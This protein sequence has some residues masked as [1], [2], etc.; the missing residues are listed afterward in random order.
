MALNEEGSLA[1]AAPALER[2]HQGIAECIAASRYL[3]CFPAGVDPAPFPVSRFRDPAADAT[4]EPLPDWWG[5]DER[6]LVYVSFGSVA[7]TFPDA[8]QA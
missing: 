2:R 7:A 4:P 6:P 1:I 5:G 3:T 8:A